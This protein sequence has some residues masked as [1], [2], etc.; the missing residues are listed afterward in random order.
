MCVSSNDKAGHFA[1]AEEFLGKIGYNKKRARIMNQLLPGLTGPKMSASDPRSKIDLLDFPELVHQKITNAICHP[2]IVE[3][4]PILAL[5][6][7]VLIPISKL[8]LARSTAPDTSARASPPFV[9]GDAPESSV[10]SIEVETGEFRHYQSYEEIE[11][12][13]LAGAL[14]P[15]ALK[16]AV[17]K[18]ITQLLAHIRNLYEKN[19]EWHAALRLGYPD[20]E[21]EYVS[22]I[23][24]VG[25]ASLSPLLGSL[26]GHGSRCRC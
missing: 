24:L 13:F 7:V 26:G 14:T 6:R 5:L 16:V 3:D 9:E 8:R 15:A 17:A 4:S 22:F 12:D 2:C 10:Y 23:S 18:S 11:L 20:S 25:T 19:P 21:E 1:Y